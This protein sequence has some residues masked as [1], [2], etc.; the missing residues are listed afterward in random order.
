[1]LAIL[2]QRN[3]AL[4]WVGQLI[5]VFG[6]W[7][8]LIA[9]PF[10]IFDL[11]GSALA[12]GAMFMAANLPRV[13]LGSVAGVFVDR[14]NR[15]RT[16]IVADL[17][18]GTLLLTLLTVHSAHFLWVIY[19][20]TFTQATIGQFFLPAKNAIIPSIVAKSDLI[21]ANSLN[22]LSENLTRLTAPALGGA[23]FALLGLASV[24][25][26]DSA[27]FLV[28][29]ALI[30]LIAVR[31]RA[32][33]EEATAR[34]RSWTALVRE[35]G[36]GLRLMRRDPIIAA[37]FATTGTAMIAEG[38]FTVLLV[39]F[40]KEVLHGDAQDFGWLASAQAIGGLVGSMLLARIGTAI[41]PALL[42]PLS[43][44]L[45]GIGDIALVN[46]PNRVALPALPVALVMIGFAGVP[47]VGFF[48]GQN[49][50][51]QAS[52]ADAFRG[53]VFGAYSTTIALLTLI[54]QGIGSVLGDRI[55]V[56][57]VFTL[58]GC[59][60]I[61]AAVV[62]FLL[63]RRARRHTDAQLEFTSAEEMTP[64]A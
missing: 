51:L 20:I 61:L 7:V 48:V 26:I 15:K 58:A 22:S 52:V 5:S 8:L 41:R 17:A 32:P 50:L 2:R 1:M 25:V 37:I 55:G 14:W 59:F 40:V 53:R 12:T 36:D 43:G 49:A 3:F 34:P 31:H 54:G 27:S 63:L 9:L 19:L 60:D 30:A 21:P 57:P 39:P 29:G 18:R 13:L 33:N 6:D 35:W 64:A 56:V 47:I 42:I 24:V 45:F 62:A 4:L 23:L 46:L 44:L 38:F 11:T 10:Y 28:S 16:M